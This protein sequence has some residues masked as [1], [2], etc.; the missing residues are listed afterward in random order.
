MLR[1]LITL[2]FLIAIAG[3]AA[4]RAGGAAA[5]LP[6]PRTALAFT[7]DGR[8]I[9]WDQ[10]VRAA[11]QADVVI[12]GENHGHPL[13]LAVAAALFDD[14]LA[15]TESAA[16][17]LEFF[18]RDDQSRLDDYLAGL[19]D[20]AAFKR[21]TGRSEGNYPEGHRQMVEAAKA[22]GRPVHAANAPRSTVRLVNRHGFERLAGLTPEQQRLFR[23]PDELPQGRYRSDFE[24]TMREMMSAH[25]GSEDEEAQSQLI[26]G[27]FR[28]QSLWD[29]TMA[30]TIA[31]AVGAGHRP[32]VHVV[33]RFHSDFD[34]GLVYALASLAPDAELLT[35]S[36]APEWS[37]HLLEGDEARADVVIYVGPPPPRPRAR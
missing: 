32:V 34:G 12:I 37:G 25:G 9:E 24:E 11:A 18:Q 17:S 3:C 6:D 33:G 36:M 10:L 20:E 13:G 16:L 35:I 26:A 30:E 22:A 5:P 1:L 2:A 14:L 4:P 31:R 15:G 28:A 23:I 27:M 21:R 19:T 8:Q 7:G 29:W